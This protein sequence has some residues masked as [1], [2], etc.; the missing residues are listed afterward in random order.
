M[1]LADQ[2]LD[3]G[4]RIFG[5][6]GNDFIQGAS[7]DDVLFGGRGSDTIFGFGGAD[8]MVAGDVA[9]SKTIK[10]TTCSVARELTG[11]SKQESCSIPG[12]ARL[13]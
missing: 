8:L 1:V 10:E 13:D 2:D 4:L 6:H 5:D 3:F 9:V 12:I 11:S 7:G